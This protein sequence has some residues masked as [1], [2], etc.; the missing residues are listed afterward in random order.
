MITQ[1][2]YLA[3]LLET[4]QAF[5]DIVLETTDA[6]AFILNKLQDEDIIGI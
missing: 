4:V 5:R 1:Y 3:I 2:K 6:L